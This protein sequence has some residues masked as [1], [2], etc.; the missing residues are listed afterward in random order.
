MPLEDNP[1]VPPVAADVCTSVP[2]DQ[3]APAAGW[4]FASATFLGAF[5]LFQVQP[6]ITKLILPWFGGGAS[7]WTTAML[8]FQTALLG[9][10]LYAHTA[11]TR[12]GR[13]WLARVHLLL[14]AA[15]LFLLPVIPAAHWAPRGDE[16]PVIRILALLGAT[17]GLQYVL[18]ASTSPLLQALW[19]RGT[20][21]EVPYRWYALSNAGSLLALVTYPV[22]VEPLLRTRVQASVWSAA[23][24]VYA[25]LVGFSFL[26]SRGATAGALE[27]VASA[28]VP[29]ATRF[30]WIL[31][32]TAASAL[33]LAGTEFLSENIVPVPLLW[34]LPLSAYLLSFIVC[35]SRARPYR[36]P[37]F[38]R[39]AIG[40]LL[41]MAA[42]VQLPWLAFHVALAT[43]IVTTGVF[44][45][46]TY[47]HNQVVS[48]K[49]AAGALTSFYLCIA[50]GGA[51]GGLLIAVA[52]PLMLPLPV[53]FPL[54][55]VGCAA[56]L[57]ATEWRKRGA[58]LVTAA[59]L[60]AVV[61]VAVMYAGAL[62]VD[63]LA[64]ARNF[65]GTLRVTEEYAGLNPVVRARILT[66]G[67]IHHGSQ[68]LDPKLRHQPTLYY[69][70][71]SGIQFAIERTRHPHQRV[72]IV[73][74][75]TGTLAAYGREG[76][77]YRFYE[78]NPRVIRFATTLFTYLTDSPAHV[79]ISLGDARLVLQRERPQNYDV[80]VLDAFSSDAIPTH[81]LT[82][83][84][85]AL[86]LHHL[87]PDGILAFHVSSKVLRLVPVVA[88]GAAFYHLSGLVI[89]SGDDPARYR[90]SAT[91]LL[92]SR[93]PARLATTP[94]SPFWGRGIPPWTDPAVSAWT[95]DYSNIWRILH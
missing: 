60:L 38:V 93:D 52:A 32:P 85:I 20:N 39:L 54:V 64:L 68:L 69:A 41:S 51:L 82:R 92:L 90:R 29:R 50:L 40:A 16:Q 80:L 70:S 49:P 21:K 34:V 31:F 65:Y 25:V 5:L 56:V 14:L 83:E 9:G 15:S 89:D 55:I 59:A 18:L 91:W 10:Y 46:S 8:F 13:G 12:L 35:F 84:A 2:R 28:Q 78:I 3:L 66:H 76:D 33:L 88:A 63:T 87:R 22:L 61:Y 42:L 45:V 58:R 81:L 57:L 24:A 72:G 17:I 30:A 23:Y 74:L 1:T 73:G 95:D 67:V 19:V 48:R 26:V 44:L 37:L 62:A 6:L 77:V 7:V 4:L 75:G 53:D 94:S 36:A 27:P 47:C 79:E 86:Y 71:G 11:I 43:A